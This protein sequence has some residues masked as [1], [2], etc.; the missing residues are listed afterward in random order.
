MRAKATL[1]MCVLAALGAGACS[2]TS[3]PPTAAATPVITAPAPPA[4]GVIG[5]A[6]GQS[7]SEKDRAAAIA[8]Q[9]DAVSSG[10]RKSWNGEKDA[11]GFVTPGAESGSC[12]DY[13]H[14]IFVNGRPQEAK[15]QACRQNGE[16]RVTS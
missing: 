8:A 3:E 16:W 12:R 7:L 6:I 15:G 14:R 10:A 13:T 9:Q 1:A 2:S 5:G 4:P 11:Y